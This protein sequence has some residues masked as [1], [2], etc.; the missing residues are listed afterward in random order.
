MNFLKIK[1]SSQFAIFITFLSQSLILLLNII[2]LRIFAIKLPEEGFGALLFIRRF[3]GL[4]FPI[5]ILNQNISLSKY[6]SANIEKRYV[7]LLLSFILSFFVF[8]ICIIIA[9]FFNYNIA[10]ILFN[11]GALSNLIVP[12]VLFLFATGIQIIMF[13]FYRG[14]HEF[15][16]MN[17]VAIVF[18]TI[19]VCVIY[20]IN[21]NTDYYNSI[22]NY[23]YYVSI[24]SITFYSLLAVFDFLNSKESFRSIKK[25]D[26]LKEFIIYGLSRIP[27]GLI[28]A[29]I[30][31]IPIFIATK[32]ISLTAAAY[33]GIVISITRIVQRLGDPFSLIFL[34]KFSF[35]KSQNNSVMITSKVQQIIEFIF[36]YPLLFGSFVYFFSPELIP[37]WFGDKYIIIIDYLKYL[38]P[39]LGISLGYVLLRGILDGLY[40][41]PYLN[42]ITFLGAVALS[43]GLIVSYIFKLGILGLVISLGV[44]IV[45]LSIVSIIILSF[46][47]KLVYIKRNILFSIIWSV[48]V[49]VFIVYA[50]SYFQYSIII[51]ILIKSILSLLIL[52]VSF[53]FYRTINIAKFR[54]LSIKGLI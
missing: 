18:W 29:S 22:A 39:F 20:F 26:N 33:I 1:K 31:F 6:V 16:K 48:I 13:G 15:K 43:L 5:F 14:K 35:Y 36:T 53:I 52:V 17:I 42:I 32:T 12:I 24:I 40:V 8:V 25:V 10:L 46:K 7:Y 49:F 30:Y 21:F 23:F 47:L 41:F 38:A 37:I 2:L 51:N 54:E 11:D 3:V 19:Q 45:I 34:P 4:V 50:N 9:Y 28:F 27:N 44:G